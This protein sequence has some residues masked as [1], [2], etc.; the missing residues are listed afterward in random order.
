MS[1][2]AINGV[3]Y[4]RYGGDQENGAPKIIFYQTLFDTKE[5]R[6]KAKKSLE[7][8]AKSKENN[9][10]IKYL[11]YPKDYRSQGGYPVGITDKGVEELKGM[12][13]VKNLPDGGGK[14]RKSKR[15]S[16]KSKS[17]KKYKRSKSSKRKSS[18]RKSKRHR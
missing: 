18:K 16:S 3:K 12:G 14:R 6:N 7:A 8:S 17:S 5:N 10:E 9:Y 4:K 1:G 11:I 15:K 2:V 13:L